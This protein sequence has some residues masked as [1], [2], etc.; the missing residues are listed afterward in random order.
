MSQSR[1]VGISATVIVAIL[2][3]GA[4]PAR[5][6]FP[7]P[8]SRPSPAPQTPAEDPRVAQVTTALEKQGL[9]VL[10]AG[11]FR[12]PGFFQQGD[13]TVWWVNTA[14]NYAQ[15]NDRDVSRQA[16]VT[17]GVMYDILVNEP[18]ATI[19]SGAQYW[20][21]YGLVLQ[22]HMG[23]LTTLVK[24]IGAAR[25]DPEKDTAFQ[26]FAATVRFRVYD[27]EKKQFVDEKDF[28]NKNFTR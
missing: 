25:T 3:G 22:T 20:T 18:P 16:L 21:K 7:F 23:D 2:L 13:T 28:M 27:A 11:S 5:A 26:A 12:G 6:Q 8:T 4:P 9:K 10:G 17:W 15:P 1:W 14:A 24:A 19:I